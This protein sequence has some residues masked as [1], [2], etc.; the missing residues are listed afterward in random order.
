MSSTHEGKTP[1]TTGVDAPGRGEPGLAAVLR[2]VSGAPAAWNR[3]SRG[4]FLVI[5]VG[6]LA[7]LAVV[8]LVYVSVGNQDTRTKAALARRER[9][10]DVPQQMADYLSVRIIGA[11]ALASYYDNSGIRSGRADAP[12]DEPVLMREASDYG[13]TDW[14][15]SSVTLDRATAFNPVGSYVRLRD[16]AMG[17]PSRENPD[18]AFT[19][20]I[21]ARMAPSDPWLASNEPTW[22]GFKPGGNDFTA[23]PYDRY[24]IEPAGAKKDWLHISNVAPDGK[25]VNLYNLAPVV[26]GRRIGNLN[27]MPGFGTFA[28]DFGALP[29]LSE[30]LSL[31]SG[32]DNVGDADNNGAA[33][34]F[35]AWGASVT[36]AN[37]VVPAYWDSWQRGAFRLAQEN[38]GP[39]NGPGTAY[40]LPYQWADAD[41]DGMFDS[42]WMQLTDSR[43]FDLSGDA[44]RVLNLLESDGKFRYFFAVRI[45]DASGMVNVN[46]ATDLAAAPT[47]TYPAGLTPAD[48]DL[49]RLL[50]LHDVYDG[51]RAKP[52][53]FAGLLGRAQAG[54]DG[55]VN[56]SATEDP[57]GLAP[58]NY[59]PVP[60]VTPGTA[61]PPPANTGYDAIRAY[62]T[63]S[64]AYTS[65]RLSLASGAYVPLASAT[66]PSIEYRGMNLYA[67]YAGAAFDR[68]GWDINGQQGNR[69]PRDPIA[70]RL[71]DFVPGQ[72]GAT[73][74]A[75]GATLKVFPTTTLL[76]GAGISTNAG[77]VHSPPPYTPSAA[78]G[79]GLYP[80]LPRR[81]AEHYASQVASTLGTNAAIL[82][83]A[84]A[85]I[86][87][88][89]ASGAFGADDL[90]ELLTYRASNDINVLSNLERVLG[91]RDRLPFDLPVAAIPANS[92]DPR[93]LDPLRSNRGPELELTRDTASGVRDQTAG[94]DGRADVKARLQL[95][96]DVRQRLTTVSGARSI[97]TG[98]GLDGRGVNFDRIDATEVKT[99]ATQLLRNYVSFPGQPIALASLN[100]I[101]GTY[102]N[103]LLPYS[104]IGASWDR[105]AGQFNQL[106]TTTYGYEGSETAILAAA[107]MAAN[108]GDLADADTVP[109]AWTLILNNAAYAGLNNNPAFP[110]WQES[111]TGAG[112][113]RRLD[114]DEAMGLRGTAST[115]LAA[116]GTGGSLVAPAVNIYGI[117]PQPF[118][119]AM[120]TFTV[121]TDRPQLATPPGSSDGWDPS[122]PGASPRPVDIRPDVT[123]FNYDLMYRVAAFRLH[124]PFGVDI[125]IGDPAAALNASNPGTAPAI[126]FARQIDQGDGAAYSL[127]RQRDFYYLRF[128]GR[129][130]MLTGLTEEA[131]PGTLDYPAAALAG[132]LDVTAK[133]VTIKAGAS[134]V[135]YAT[136]QMPRTIIERNLLTADTNFIPAGGN[137]RAAI[138]ALIE[139]QLKS[140]PNAN[141]NDEYVWIPEID[142]SATGPTAGQLGSFNQSRLPN[143]QGA[144]KPWRDASGTLDPLAF[145][146]LMHQNIDGRD[147]KLEF[148]EPGTPAPLAKLIENTEVQLWRAVRAGVPGASSPAVAGEY[149]TQ[150]ISLPGNTWDGATPL[151]VT[152]VTAYVRNDYSN[153]QL[154]D[155]LRVPLDPTTNGYVDLDARFK[156]A[157][158]S[159]E[160]DIEVSGSD[161][162]DGRYL[163]G[164]TATLWVGVRRPEDPSIAANR[165][166]PAGALPGFCLESKAGG[167]YGATPAVPSW[168]TFVIQDQTDG[169]TWKRLDAG[170][171]DSDARSGKAAQPT[172]RRW[173]AA[174]RTEIFCPAI[175]FSGTEK[176][177]ASTAEWETG[178]LTRP[179]P[180]NSTTPNV[181]TPYD[182]QYA[183]LITSNAPV[184]SSPLAERFTSTFFV[185]DGSGNGAKTH[186]TLRV[187]DMLLPM[188][189]GPME[190]PLTS[191]GTDNKDLDARWTTLGEAIAGAMGYDRSTRVNDPSVLSHPK[192]MGV[193]A[194]RETF[195]PLF[196]RG[197]LVLDDFAPFFNVDGDANGTFTAGTGRDQRFFTQIPLALNVLDMFSAG[198]SGEESVTR[199]VPGLININAAPLAVARCLPMLSP[200]TR[201]ERSE[202]QTLRVTAAAG[203]TFTLTLNR[204]GSATTAPIPVGASPAAVQA[205]LEKLP[206][207]GRDNVWV[208]AGDPDN[209]GTGWDAS[210]NAYRQ[211]HYV[212]SF[213]GALSMLDLP[214][215]SCSGGTVAT[216]AEGSNVRV[217]PGW[218]GE[219]SG[220]DQSVDLAATLVSNRDKIEVPLRPQS[221][222]VYDPANAAIEVD[223]I[224]YSHYD[225][226]LGPANPST[227][228]DNVL[229]RG[230]ETD[231]TALSETPG[232]QS[233]GALMTLRYRGRS[234]GAADPYEASMRTSID[235]MGFATNPLSLPG[236]GFFANNQSGLGV[237]SVLLG[238][239]LPASPADYVI[240]PPPTPPGE[241]VGTDT[242]PNEYKEKL[243]IAN[244]VV[245]STTTRSDYFI[246]WFLVHGYQQSDVENL[247]PTDVL[248]PTIARRFVMVVDRSNVVKTGDKPRVLLF[249]E[250]PVSGK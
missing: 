91:G 151:P 184:G 155:R 26:G 7:L 58:G 56:P 113:G 219:G 188:G 228:P 19:G 31:L 95:D 15:R 180:P 100:A 214:Q 220:I 227:S 244:A 139:R 20:T 63:G 8:M 189:I 177:A 131:D 124:N 150:S 92:P 84:G 212:I 2:G 143:D 117:E 250:V 101:F 13:W 181:D 209:P 128:G 218:W 119:T 34:S 152:S 159:A 176:V 122:D 245:N 16:P 191:T 169:V 196:D 206:L 59:G 109:G 179:M 165:Q 157:A 12:A 132:G 211:V 210:L 162:S 240:A 32:A 74:G 39:A 78:T 55:I 42:R 138:R 172:L 226:A 248:T 3:R 5:V 36:A 80:S 198:V 14:T 183:Q 104:N 30:G 52:S 130:F 202:V 46:T 234:L 236:T 85:A 204:G 25:F 154:V 178:T 57:S 43:A 65:L 102:C 194:G 125:T 249:K 142:P 141:P 116:A 82:N 87:Q 197:N 199:A 51:Y 121:Y 71:W 60:G 225:A 1:A 231:I 144:F 200:M 54:Y 86:S 77:D 233:L 168:N 29:R 217:G 243:A 175:A 163:D 33:G 96:A 230:V 22:L 223:S 156:V 134:V 94:A 90:A 158:G 11:D 186:S 69:D 229:T 118:V 133:P 98:R 44:S 66:D 232:F 50:T 149:A 120:A 224:R 246:A 72:D 62:T 221:R 53:L 73:P 215:M 68:F 105:A 83:D 64:M 171:F 140:G 205:A 235:Y 97:F 107:H 4:S 238:K 195:R 239:Y 127:D 242:M 222:L 182:Q 247:G 161:A 207:V 193:V 136:S 114:L 115:R 61:T 147:I 37:R 21:P 237:D 241:D 6:T 88:F 24:A 89:Q 75:G 146:Q 40:Y 208:S 203:S 167:D 112:D 99:N 213:T 190:S 103:A 49:R 137:K 170:Y 135:V 18:P 45:I 216:A 153:D 148:R 35:T 70:R 23:A 166:I 187:G 28:G 47:A 110:W 201:A 93:R 111:A 126:P 27:A 108:M 164:I 41:G 192:S 67:V 160:D 9:L 173:A 174:T 185:R 145:G 106:K 76:S 38:R 129:T 79:E 81:R 48:V 17:P 10:D 123:E